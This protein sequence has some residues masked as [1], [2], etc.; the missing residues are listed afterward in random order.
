MVA[1]AVLSSVQSYLHRLRQEGIAV[2]FGVLFGSQATGAADEESDIDLLVVAP[3][4]DDRIDRRD[5]DRLWDAA[6][7]TDSR[8]EPVPCGE[9]SWREDARTPIIEI[10][11]REG[12]RV[13]LDDER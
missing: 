5:V 1:P 13:D 4:F 3:Q 7:L 2:R 6:A 9:R 8:I 10:A 11:R 12:T